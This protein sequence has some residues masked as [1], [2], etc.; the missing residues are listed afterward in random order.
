MLEP[1]VESRKKQPGHQLDLCL[2]QRKGNMHQSLMD[3]F[4]SDVS[5][6]IRRLSFICME[7]CGF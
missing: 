3:G 5:L 1:G 6:E 2:L 4:S 7:S